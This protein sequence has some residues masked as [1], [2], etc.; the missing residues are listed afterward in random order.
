MSSASTR[1]SRASMTWILSETLAP[2][3]TA[4]SGR[5]LGCD[6][7]VQVADLLLHQEPGHRVLHVVRDPFRG[8]VGAVRAAEGV[9]DEHGR[10]RVLHQAAREGGIVLLLLGVE[11]H[12][13]EEQHAAVLQ[14]LRR[15]RTSSP[16]QSEA[17]G[18]SRCSSSP[19]RA[20]TGARLNSG[21]GPLLGPAQVRG[22]GQ[23]RP[24]LDQVLE[25]GQGRADAR[26]V[27]DAAAL[28]GDVV[29]HAHEDVRP[30]EVP[31]VLDRLLGHRDGPRRRSGRAWPCSG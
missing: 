1:S 18:T 3:S 28:E 25:G 15:L 10:A 29:V 4:T 14:G 31:Q 22:Q 30:L 24:A 16:T 26:V 9:V 21:V 23:A 8:G 17:I 5:S 7:H 20:A 2:P 12:V 6:G 11:A 13:L 19:S 27:G